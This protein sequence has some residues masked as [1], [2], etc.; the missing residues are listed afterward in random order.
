MATKV[1][2]KSL[3]HPFRLEKE[4][5]AEEISPAVDVEAGASPLARLT[6]ETLLYG[7]IIVLAVGLRL[8]HLGAY[9]LSGEEA[10]QSLAALALYHGH[11]VEP[12]Q[13]SPLLLSLNT[14]TFVLFGISDAAARLATVLL[15]TA[16]VVL[17]LT[18]RRQLGRRVCLIASLLLA[19]SPTTLFLSR[20]L[21]S[22][23][24]VAVGGLMLVAGFFNWVDESRPRW[25]WL[26]AGGLALLLTSG[27][28]AYSLLLVFSLIVLVRWSA[29]KTRVEELIS[30]DASA[31]ADQEDPANIGDDADRSTQATATDDSLASESRE[32]SLRNAAI[33]LLVSILVL[34]T[35]ATFNISGFSQIGNFVADWFSRFGFQTRPEAGFN[36]VFLLTIYE[37]LIL[38]AGLTG[39]A[40]TLTL[41]RNL[42]ETIFA[43][44]FIGILVLDFIMGGRPNGN[45]ILA[46]VPLTFLAAIALAELGEGLRRW[47]SWDN[48]GILSGVGL[49]I[50]VF[51]YIGLAG[52]LIRTCG[53]EDRLCQ[54]SWLQPVAALALFMVIVAFF[55]LLSNPG[56]ALR[57]AALAGVAVG[58]LA[59]IN[60]GWRLNYG[61]L[62]NLGYQPLAGIPASTELGELVDTLTTQSDVRI[63]DPTLLDTTLTGVNSPALRWQLRDFG[64]LQQVNGL[65]PAEATTAIIT[66]PTINEGLDL[67]Q[68][69]F[70]QDFGLDAVW[71]PVGLSPKTFIQWLIYR[72][73]NERPQSNQV[74]LW[75]RV[76]EQ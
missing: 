20:T 59:T 56:S 2:Q 42:L 68:A 41:H 75:L 15:G 53:A 58:L 70:G 33:F 74:I 71:S 48:E 12:G 61:P 21:N 18:L 4:P 17:P 29:F 72:Q 9:P 38:V 40:L 45:L 36:A 51:G 66:P 22:E 34:A 28:M 25:L 10:E 37:P 30:T 35:T 24:G 54:Y 47:G 63:G 16:L 7:L 69:Y 31:R 49:V 57:G 46:V 50:A 52:W 23:I 73:I 67:G 14:L 44:W 65:S 64:H 8:W 76:E 32:T 26:I 13:Y 19:I 5:Q 55:G 60:I 1:K 11:P 39:L 3:D 43:G 27:P 6:V 62:M